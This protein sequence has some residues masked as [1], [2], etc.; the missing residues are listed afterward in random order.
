MF[1]KILMTAAALSALTFGASAANAH[2]NSGYGYANYGHSSYGYGCQ[3]VY[4]PYGWTWYRA[5][6]C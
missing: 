4:I 5:S 6:R 2:Y 3:T 1:K